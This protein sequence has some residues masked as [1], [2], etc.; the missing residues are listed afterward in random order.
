MVWF[1]M[2]LRRTLAR[3]T[4]NGEAGGGSVWSGW[5]AR[6][7]LGA[8]RLTRVL[9]P[10]RGRRDGGGDEDGRVGERRPYAR[11]GRDDERAEE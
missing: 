3:L 8:L 10:G 4:M 1:D 2:G 5:V 6:G 11:S 9:G 7:G